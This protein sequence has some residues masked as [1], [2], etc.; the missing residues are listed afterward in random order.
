[1]Q[2]RRV[3][4]NEKVTADRGRVALERGPVVYA[5]EWADSPDKHVRNI[6]LSNNEK[7]R[8]DFK[9]AL[10]NGIEVIEGEADAFR[11]DADHR[12]EHTREAFT[13]IPYYA[14]ANRGRGQME[15]W[16]ADTESA[17]HPSP[18]PTLA[19]KSKVTASGTTVTDN[20]VKD[21]R[22]VADGEEPASSSDASSF[23][24][25][26]KRGTHEWIEYEFAK[27][28]TVSSADVYWFADPRRAAIQE[29]A[30]WRI[31]YKDGMEWKPVE[32]AG[33]YGV[34]LDRFNHIAFKPVETQALR[35]E[36]TCQP[37]HS[38]GIEEWRVQ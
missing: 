10:L 11:Y 16:I 7:L 4:A 34:A 2:V 31:L 18:Y 36:L 6:V 25:S 19:M 27:P 35:L 17:V 3:V 5:A 23:D 14:W 37:G 9:P 1:M 30:A 28:A 33:S 13:A 38:A 15:V 20:G 12:L 8:A 32:A 26:P 22:N 24:W 21:P 29:P